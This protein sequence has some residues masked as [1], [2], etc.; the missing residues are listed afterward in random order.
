MAGPPPVVFIQTVLLTRG[1]EESGTP[2]HRERGHL[3]SPAPIPAIRPNLSTSQ[4]QPRIVTGARSRP[5]ITSPKRDARGSAPP[6]PNLSIRPAP[7]RWRRGRT[8]YNTLSVLT[9]V[10][11]EGDPFLS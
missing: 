6:G 5:S 11:P 4:E 10:L 2:L 8:P 7:S 3:S 1:R 9:L